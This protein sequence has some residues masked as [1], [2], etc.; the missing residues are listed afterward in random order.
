L[1]KELNLVRIVLILQPL[2][3]RN[4]DKLLIDGHHSFEVSKMKT[5]QK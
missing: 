3:T 5:F 2:I 4:F 1:M